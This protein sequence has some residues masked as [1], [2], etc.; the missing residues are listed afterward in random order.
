MNITHAILLKYLH[1]ECSEEELQTVNA[2]LSENEENKKALFVGEAIY[3]SKKLKKYNDPSFLQNEKIRLYKRIQRETAAEKRRVILNNLLRYAAVIFLLV[4]IGIGILH[5]R[6]AKSMQTI[7]TNNEKVE[8]LTLSDGS[9]VWLNRSSELKYPKQFDGKKRIVHLKGEAYFE[10]TKNTEQAFV[11]ETENMEIT[12]LGTIF[13]VISPSRNEGVPSVT[14]IEGEIR[15]KGNNQ[16]GMVILLPGQK[17]E[18]DLAAHRLYVRE[19]YKASL[20]TVWREGLIPLNLASLEEIG[21]MLEQLYS[22]KV[23]VDPSISKTTYS[24][25]LKTQDSIDQMLRLLQNSIPIGFEI[26]GGNVYIK[27]Y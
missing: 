26:K 22:M 2:W 13:D 17:A 9:K 11:V 15:V 14:L 27:T 3:K 1:N 7:V 16:E 24:G 8:Q 10:V 23:Y 21:K 19:P 25:V 18:L 20:E 6:S 5:F 4:G 12:V